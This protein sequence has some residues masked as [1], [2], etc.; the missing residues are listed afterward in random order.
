MFR[1]F[2]LVLVSGV[3]YFYKHLL[4]LFTTTPLVFVHVR[5]DKPPDLTC[6]VK[7]CCV[8]EQISFFHSSS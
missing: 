2:G 8:T 4:L 3:P 5:E 7:G 6:A 1:Y